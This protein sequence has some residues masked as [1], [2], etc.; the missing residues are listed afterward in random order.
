MYLYVYVYTGNWYGICQIVGRE[1]WI[2]GCTVVNH[3]QS[4]SA[5]LIFG[6]GK[7]DQDHQKIT[8]LPPNFLSNSNSW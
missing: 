4:Q 7:L 2:L 8:A 3:S 6:G 5:A 1:A